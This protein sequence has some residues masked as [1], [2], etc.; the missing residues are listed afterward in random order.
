[1]RWLDGVADAD[2]QL[3]QC[4]ESEQI[5]FT[6]LF[7]TLLAESETPVLIVLNQLK[8]SRYVERNNYVKGNDEIPCFCFVAG[9]AEDCVGL[10][11]FVSF[12]QEH[13]GKIMMWMQEFHP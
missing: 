7:D 5:R 10:T 4:I 1:M 11:F 8:R 9:E 2:L 3:T 13:D 12:G 6:G